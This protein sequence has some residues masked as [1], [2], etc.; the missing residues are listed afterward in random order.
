MNEDLKIATL[1]LT[2]R[3]EH[4]NCYLS[5]QAQAIQ[6]IERTMLAPCDATRTVSGGYELRIPHYTDDGLDKIVQNLPREIAD[7]ADRKQ[8]FSESEA[9]LEG[10][11][12]A[13]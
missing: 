10:T 5:G 6:A 3:I 2:L 8:C 1:R 12:R 4:N 7:D 13:W 9:R 11:D